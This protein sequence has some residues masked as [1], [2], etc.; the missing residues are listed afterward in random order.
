M[1]VVQGSAVPYDCMTAADL[2]FRARASNPIYLQY[3]IVHD[4]VIVP[5][6]KLASIEKTVFWLL[7]EKPL[8][9]C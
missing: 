5:V 8:A 7:K 1:G 9:F 3:W 4:S 2:E 6:M